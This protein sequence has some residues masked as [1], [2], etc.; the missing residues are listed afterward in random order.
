MEEAQCFLYQLWQS[1]QSLTDMGTSQHDVHSPAPRFSYFVI[2]GCIKLSMEANRHNCLRSSDHQSSALRGLAV[3]FRFNTTSGGCTQPQITLPIRVLQL[4]GQKWT[5]NSCLLNSPLG[6]S[7]VD[8][9]LRVTTCS[10]CRIVLW[11]PDLES[12]VLPF[13]SIPN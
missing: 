11:F 3:L 10:F 5:Q 13:S 7:T 4:P 1:R 12:P 2:L 6:G 9:E 8:L